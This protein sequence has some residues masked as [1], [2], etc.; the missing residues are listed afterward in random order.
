MSGSSQAVPSSGISALWFD[1]TGS[2]LAGA[3]KGLYLY[4]LSSSGKLTLV[5]PPVAPGVRFADVK[6]DKSGHL[7]AISS[8]GLY[9]YT[10]KNGTLVPAPGS[11]HP[12]AKTNS[13]AVLPL[14]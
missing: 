9:I 7:F 2:Y 1:P 8:T 12:L 5:Q 11:P 14:Q 10:L 3:G 4:H 13:L 6:W